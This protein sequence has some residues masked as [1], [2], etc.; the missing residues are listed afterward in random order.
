M[1]FEERTCRIEKKISLGDTAG[2]LRLQLKFQQSRLYA[3]QM[4]CVILSEEGIV[5]HTP[6]E[7]K[8]KIASVASGKELSA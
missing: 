8:A 6:S 2:T 3:E 7:A 1:A 4:E 5:L